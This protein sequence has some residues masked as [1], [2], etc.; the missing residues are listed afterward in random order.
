MS[1][2][3]NNSS[4]RVGFISINDKD[5]YAHN[6]S[7]DLTFC[8]LPEQFRSIKS[9]IENLLKLPIFTIRDFEDMDVVLHGSEEHFN[10]HCTKLQNKWQ[11]TYS[12][13]GNFQVKELGDGDV[14]AMLNVINAVTSMGIVGDLSIEQ[15]MFSLTIDKLS[16]C[17]KIYNFYK[18]GDQVYVGEDGKDI[19]FEINGSFVPM[20]FQILRSYIAD[21][22]LL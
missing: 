6:S 16:K 9:A 13:E 8:V 17:P 19:K 12:H 11:L 3:G 22:K 5:C 4:E 1:L 21:G 2:Y 20:F 14:K 7:T 18:V 10:I 15:A